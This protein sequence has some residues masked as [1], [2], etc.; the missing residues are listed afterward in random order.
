MSWR[1]SERSREVRARA[2]G[3]FTTVAVAGAREQQ[4]DGAALEKM[5]RGKRQKSLESYCSKEALRLYPPIKH[6]GKEKK[7]GYKGKGRGWAGREGGEERGEQ[8]RAEKATNGN[9]CLSHTSI[10]LENKLSEGAWALWPYFPCPRTQ[11]CRE[12]LSLSLRGILLVYF[13]GYLKME[14]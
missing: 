10:P 14:F 3:L 2:V 5:L 12:G 1:A 11:V 6:K 9:L 4:G 7:E 8:G 13:E